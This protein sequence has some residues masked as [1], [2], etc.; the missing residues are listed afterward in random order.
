[1]PRVGTRGLGGER[2]CWLAVT[3]QEDGFR[4][5]I[6]IEASGTVHFPVLLNQKGFGKDS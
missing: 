1:M 3:C 6:H 2:S 5:G 4:Y